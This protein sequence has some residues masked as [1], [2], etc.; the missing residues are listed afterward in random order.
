[1]T[2]TFSTGVVEMTSSYVSR[3]GS[4]SASKEAVRASSLARAAQQISTT[5]KNMQWYSV[6]ATSGANRPSLSVVRQKETARSARKS[7]ED[8]GWK[9]EAGLY[10][11]Y[12]E[13]VFSGY[14]NNSD[15][16]KVIN[17]LDRKSTV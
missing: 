12:P 11:S 17:I 4:P 14:K 1:M 8:E 5:S 15:I 13:T 10:I 9:D 16:G 3:T 7:D 6:E 2:S